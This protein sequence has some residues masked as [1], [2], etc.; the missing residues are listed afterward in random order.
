MQTLPRNEFISRIRTELLVIVLEFLN[1]KSFKTG[2]NMHLLRISV[3]CE[4]RWLFGVEV[5]KTVCM[6][7]LFNLS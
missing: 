5:L 1:I 2:P 3:Y 6:S 4:E 7:V